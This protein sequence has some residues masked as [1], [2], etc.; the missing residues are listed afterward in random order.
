MGMGRDMIWRGGFGCGEEIDRCIRTM[1]GFVGELAAGGVDVFAAA[2]AEAGVDAVLFQMLHE[3]V[4]RGFFGF[5]E[6]GLVDG[7]VFDDIDEVGGHLAEILTSSSASWRLSLKP[8]KRIYSKVISLP[9]ILIEV[10]ECFDERLD[11]IGLVDG[12]DLVALLVVG[13][14]EG[15]GQLEFDLV[16]TQLADH[17]GD[18]GGGDGDAAG[19]HGEAVGC[20]M[21]SMALRTLR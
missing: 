11:I 6:E 13:G 21:R 9:V 14:V 16:V 15:E 4:D 10:V 3:L 1:N 18:A 12:H 2:A 7:V 17:F 19:A 20:V 8:L 5:L